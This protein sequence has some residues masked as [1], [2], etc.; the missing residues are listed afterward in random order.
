MTHPLTRTA[1]M[2]LPTEAQFQHVLYLQAECKRLQRCLG[3]ALESLQMADIRIHRMRGDLDTH[4]V[5]LVSR[6]RRFNRR[7][8]FNRHP[9]SPREP[10]RGVEP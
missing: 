3:V 8:H 5:G 10:G 1:W 9:R 6:G 2:S 7:G 4:R